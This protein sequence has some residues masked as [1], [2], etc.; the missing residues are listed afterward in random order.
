MRSILVPVGGSETDLSLFETALAA[1]R[2]ISGH[3]Q[4]V[5]VHIDAGEAAVHTPHFGFAM[6]P[7]LANAL[8]ALE[9]SARTRSADARQH[10]S[11]FCLRSCVEV[12]D[13]PMPS[14][15]VTAS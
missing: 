1:A 9:I 5:H 11:D 10:F 8:K 15:D 3:L 2:P 13:V 6:G 14:Q 4:F 12:R 7:A